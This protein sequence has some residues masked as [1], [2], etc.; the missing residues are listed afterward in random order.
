[1]GTATYKRI[2]RFT[3]N[4]LIFWRSRL[5]CEQYNSRL[6]GFTLTELLVVVAVSSILLVASISI[7]NP[8]Q[9]IY[10]A[11]DTKRKA[12]LAKIQTAL[13][14]F[15][16]DNGNYPAGSVGLNALFQGT[17]QYLPKNPNGDP[18][19]SDIY[20]YTAVPSGCD[21]VT[22]GQCSGYTLTTCLE[23]TADPDRDTASSPSC[24]SNLWS[25]TV[26]NP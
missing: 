21:N 25:K 9:Q 22:T 16:S 11:N 5:L 6:P 19:T 17:P 14:L 24:A 12:N 4:T 18:K 3:P 23:N 15:R 20:Y 7:L 13:E 10:K 2:S 26:E 1:M 8:G